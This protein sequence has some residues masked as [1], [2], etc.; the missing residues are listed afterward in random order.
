MMTT[1][2]SGG[3]LEGSP[4]CIAALAVG[5][6]CDRAG[7]DHIDICAFVKLIDTI[8]CIHKLSADSRSLGEVELTAEGMK[9]DGF[10]CRHMVF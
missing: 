7:I 10:R 4:D 1:F 9:G 2:A 6:F 5:L 3:M 8:P